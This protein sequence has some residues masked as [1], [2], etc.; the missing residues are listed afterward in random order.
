MLSRFVRGRVSITSTKLIHCQAGSTLK[1]WEFVQETILS[2]DEDMIADFTDDIDT[3]L[4]FVS[5]SSY[6]F[7]S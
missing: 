1:D 2:H 3:L 6:L 7:V 4:V 5:L